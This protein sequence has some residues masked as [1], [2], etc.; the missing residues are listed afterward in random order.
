[1]LRTSE[2]AKYFKCV[3]LV[4]ALW[5]PSFIS[6]G[7]EAADAFWGARPL[8]SATA[9]AP[10]EVTNLRRFM[11]DSISPTHHVARAKKPILLTL[12]FSNDNFGPSILHGSGGQWPYGGGLCCSGGSSLA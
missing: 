3:S 4:G 10:E 1:M 7:G 12:A 11:L 6:A 8:P 2:R 5:H 9:A